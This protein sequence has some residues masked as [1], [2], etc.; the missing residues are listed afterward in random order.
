MGIIG[1]IPEIAVQ[2]PAVIE[3]I[4]NA[5]KDGWESLKDAGK[6]LLEGLWEGISDKVEWLKSKVS[7]VVDTIKSW[8][9][10]EDG[11]DEH[12][13]SKWANGVFRYVME[14]GAEGL[15]AGLPALMSSVGDVTT[16]VK[17]GMDFEAANVEFSS[18]GLGMSSAAMVNSLGDAEQSGGTV[19]FNLV[20]PD[21]TPLA[22]YIFKPLVDYA[23]AN[24]TPIL[25][26]I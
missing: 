20:L 2:L 19:T 15:E 18:S 22:S 23:K 26:P 3:A 13:P 4:V 6:Y 7:G 9:T 5:L 21:G 10:G 8:F 24:G 17:N 12:S 11:F 25:N 16:R 1:A 14:G